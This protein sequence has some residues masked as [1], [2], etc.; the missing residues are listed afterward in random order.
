ME[1]LRDP[2][3]EKTYCIQTRID[4]ASDSHKLKIADDLS[5]LNHHGTAYAL[6]T[7]TI[8]EAS[9]MGAMGLPY[10]PN[11]AIHYNESSTQ[12]RPRSR[13]IPIVRAP[14]VPNENA[15]G[16]CW[17]DYES[18][19]G[20]EQQYD[21][22]TWRMYNRIT[23]YRKQHPTTYGDSRNDSNGSSGYNSS[24]DENFLDIKPFQ[25]QAVCVEFCLE[26]KDEE[27]FHM[28]L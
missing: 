8:G 13:A 21:Q 20:H 4:V 23:Q 3:I 2:A 26:T 11:E 15:T 19:T 5:L 12:L 1:N 14:L 22:A 16:N 28:D 24:N 6:E 27:I 9:L 10:P 18:I 25:D 17:A 7:M